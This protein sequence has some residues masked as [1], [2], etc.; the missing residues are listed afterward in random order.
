MVCARRRCQ[1]GNGREREREWYL[2][3]THEAEYAYGRGCCK[4]GREEAANEPC[5]VSREGK[6]EALPLASRL[7][8]EGSPDTKEVDGESDVG[9]GADEG[10]RDGGRRVQG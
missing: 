6:A 9:H 10:G 8:C 2:D 3:D 5:T 1:K 4:V 7:P